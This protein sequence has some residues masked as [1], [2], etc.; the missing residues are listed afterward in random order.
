MAGVES[1]RIVCIMSDPAGKSYWCHSCPHLEHP[2]PDRVER[3]LAALT[4]N[5]QDFRELQLGATSALEK[6][7]LTGALVWLRNRGR[8]Q[9]RFTK[10]GTLWRLPQTQ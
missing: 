6:K 1:C 3:V 10:E 7:Q 4:T 8:V 9:S 5:W 2:W